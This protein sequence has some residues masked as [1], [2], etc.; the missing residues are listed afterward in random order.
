MFSNDKSP[1]YHT[2]DYRS[3]LSADATQ[4]FIR[5]MFRSVQHTATQS[6]HLAGP[7]FRTFSFN[8]FIRRHQKTPKFGSV[9][10]TEMLPRD[11]DK[12]NQKSECLRCIKIIVNFKFGFHRTCHCRL[13]RQRYGTTVTVKSLNV[14]RHYSH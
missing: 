14:F 1:S 3:L 12:L 2:E 11:T 9:W 4:Y 7:F 10:E 5:R 8:L 13:R 6:M